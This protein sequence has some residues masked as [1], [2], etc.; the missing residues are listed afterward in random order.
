MERLKKLGALFLF[1][2]LAFVISCG[3]GPSSIAT[4]TP[5]E[6]ATVYTLGTDASPTMP[7]IVS[8]VAT[9]SGATLSDGSI[10]ADLTT[11]PQT[12]D[13]AKLSGLHTLL[14]LNTVP[15]GTYTTVNIMLGAATISWL[16]T[17]AVATGGAPV[18]STT[19]PTLTVSNVPVTLDKPLTLNGGDTVGLF[20]DFDLAK[21]ISI[22]GSGNVTVNP[23]FNIRALGAND[24]QREI[25]CFFASFVSASGNTFVIQ[26]PHG[27]QFTVS[28]DS[29]TFFGPNDGLASFTTNTILSV[30]GT[31]DPAT[32]DIDADEV[33]VVSTDNF[34]AD[35][36]NTFVSPAPGP[37]TSLQVF[38]RSELPEGAG[39][40]LGGIST[41][42]L[43]G[44][45]IYRIGNI[46]L[47]ITTLLFNQ[48]SLTPGQR[49][50]IGGALDTST[51]PPGL[52]VHRVILQRQGQEGS[53]VSGSTV[54]SSGNAGSFTLMDNDLAGVLLP[55]P[56]TVMTTNA[57]FFINM[58][59]LSTLTGTNPI[60]LRVVGH[61]LI[62]PA[63][64]QPVFVARSVELIND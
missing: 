6:G 3:G 7:N 46:N 45:E 48:S 2:P 59:G 1:L 64:S 50:A 28:T 56:L 35:G 22:D 18:V 61:V 41:F 44:S 42:G 4:G 25:D 16:D 29:N 47:P 14:D 43:N 32:H 39:L 19:T 26:G 31:I 52:A 9:V 51:S 62:D 15:P 30:S 63:T 57:T 33:L 17:S 58:S 55:S 10:T 11:T 38:V 8:F 20:V 24:V 27:R 54:V 21:S 36:L 49:V 37:A 5:A 23:T 53:W 34:F 40:T 13:F 12:L 60:N